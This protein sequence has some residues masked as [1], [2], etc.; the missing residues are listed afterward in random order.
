LGVDRYASLYAIPLSHVVGRAL[1]PEAR[2]FNVV[3]DN[4]EKREILACVRYVDS[5]AQASHGSF[6]P[7]FGHEVAVA[8]DEGVHLSRHIKIEVA[9]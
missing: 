4:V 3:S 9:T 7:L 2:D 5:R 6:T 1:E 8:R